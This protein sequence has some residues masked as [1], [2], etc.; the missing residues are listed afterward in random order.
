MGYSAFS[1]KGAAGKEE[2]ERS[3]D[4]IQEGEGRY[5]SIPCFLLP[6]WF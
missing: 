4:G 5:E 3:Q 1:V 2:E 6:P